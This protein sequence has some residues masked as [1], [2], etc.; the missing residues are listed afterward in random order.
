M[1]LKKVISGEELYKKME[2]AINI[3]CNTVKSTLGPKGANVIINKSTFSPFITNDGVTIAESIES[4]DMVTNT[5]LEL[6][7]ESSIKTNEVVG[8]GTTTTLVLLQSIF[9][10]GLKLINKGV[11]PLKLKKELDNS[12]IDIAERINSLSREPNDSELK[13]IAIVSANDNYIGEIISEVYLKIKNKDAIFIKENNKNETVINYLKGYI[14]NSNLASNYFLK[15]L[16][17]VVY[18]N[19]YILLIDDY[20]E[21]IEDIAC[22]INF[23]LQNNSSLVI[24]AKEYSE[25]VINEILSLKIDNN[26]NIFLLRNPEYGINQ[27]SVLKD[28]SIIASAKIIEKIEFINISDLGKVENIKISNENI[29]LNY[30]MNSNI[31]ERIEELKRDIN[32]TEDKDSINRRLAMFTTG[33]AEIIIGGNTTTERRE[34]KMR[35]DDALC[36]ISAADKGVLPGSGLVFLKISK[37][38]DKINYGDII[39]KEALK[40][41]FS[42]IMF[43]GGFDSDEILKKVEDSGY[44]IIYNLNTLEYENINN[45]N[46]LD[47]TSVVLNSLTSAVSIAGMLLST[48]SIIINE[49]T[50]NINKVNDYTEM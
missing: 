18:E 10:N 30:K 35:Y 39:L 8:D 38:L 13:N 17:E 21:N 1:K 37:E 7:K 9:N 45:T 5:I 41:P 47:A 40:M 4:D 43:N 3:L 14:I 46:I 11:N 22:V 28:L 23:I 15:E 42:Q 49:H 44:K 16:K 48:T 36:A 50:N 33:M 27:I 20:L 32:I 2:E 26:I 12:L 25:S 6:A 29:V 31:N 24:L 34:K 19:P